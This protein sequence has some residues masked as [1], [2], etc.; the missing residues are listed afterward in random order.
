MAVRL[1]RLLTHIDNRDPISGYTT[2]VL[3]VSGRLTAGRSLFYIVCSG[4]MLNAP[5]DFEY[6]EHNVP[7]IKHVMAC[8]HEEVRDIPPATWK[9]FSF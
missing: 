8:Q 6:R 1:R 9:L 5:D 4:K 7:L 2:R 3:D